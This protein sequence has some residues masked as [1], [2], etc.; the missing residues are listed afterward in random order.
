AWDSDGAAW[1][2]PDLA[3]ADS[4]GSA[5]DLTF[6][7]AGDEVVFLTDDDEAAGGALLVD[8]PFQLPDLP[9][10]VPA[11]QAAETEAPP[12]GRWDLTPA[13]ESDDGIIGYVPDDGLGDAISLPDPVE[14]PEAIDLAAAI[15]LPEAIE[16]ADAI[17][18]SASAEQSVWI[19]QQ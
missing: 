12:P 10:S 7:A 13:D 17:E 18:P 5:L 15:E 16:L 9:E 11:L 3:D 4:P 8:D 2:I 19:E 14:L 1:E 6:P